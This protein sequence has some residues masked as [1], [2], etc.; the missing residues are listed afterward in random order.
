MNAPLLPGNTN[1]K[2]VRISVPSARILRAELVFSIYEYEYEEG[3]TPRDRRVVCTRVPNSSRYWR[4]DP[5]GIAFH[6]W[7]WCRLEAF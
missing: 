2:P 1:E 6:A 7:I 5:M 3:D 4:A